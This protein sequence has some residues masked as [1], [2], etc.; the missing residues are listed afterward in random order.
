MRCQTV[1]DGY[2]CG[3]LGRP[4]KREMFFLRT[5]HALVEKGSVVRSA[6]AA[7]EVPNKQHEHWQVEP[8]ELTTKGK[9]VVV[10]KSAPE[11]LLDGRLS[12]LLQA[13]HALNWYPP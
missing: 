9:D 4:D 13:M 10:V 11:T 2:G 12:D 6:S 3:M 8:V 5:W 7:K 1:K